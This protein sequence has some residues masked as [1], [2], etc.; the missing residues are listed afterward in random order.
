M[1]ICALH[2]KGQLIGDGFTLKF[3]TSS[4]KFFHTGR[5]FLLDTL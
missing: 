3:C 2:R 5:S 4:Q 1:E